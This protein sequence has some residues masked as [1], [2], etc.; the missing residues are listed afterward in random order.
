M[1]KSILAGIVFASGTP[2]FAEDIQNLPDLYQF[3]RGNDFRTIDGT[4]N[5]MSMPR[6]HCLALPIT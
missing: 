6:S 2:I 1:R 4:E 5:S 3:Q